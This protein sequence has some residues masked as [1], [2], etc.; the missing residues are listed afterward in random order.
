VLGKNSYDTAY[1]DSTRDAISRRVAAFD[2]LPAGPEKDALEPVYFGD[3]VVLLEM[4]FVHRLRGQEGKDG[5]PLNE[6][7]VLVA[8]MLEADGV[9]TPDKTI[10]QA[11]TVTGLAY[12]DPVVV[13]RE[14]FLQLSD[15]FFDEIEAKFPPR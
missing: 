7:R 4:A 1:V 2:A 14:G 6:V 8:S 3:L 13:T 11:P 5:N 12:G 9:L 15:G 10:K